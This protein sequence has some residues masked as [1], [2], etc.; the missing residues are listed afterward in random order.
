MTFSARSDRA[1]ESQPSSP[2][3]LSAVPVATPA[4]PAGRTALT[5]DF[6][7]FQI[8]VNLFAIVFSVE[9]QP[10]SIS[11]PRHLRH[12]EAAFAPAM[13]IIRNNWMNFLFMPR[14]LGTK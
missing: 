5:A 12:A 11:N 8:E 3:S 2:L 7:S 10:F 6:F 13:R 9:D 14:N 1:A 4:L